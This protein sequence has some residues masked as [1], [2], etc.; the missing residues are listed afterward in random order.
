MDFHDKLRLGTDWDKDGNN[1]STEITN[2]LFAPDHQIS[3]QT[4]I[5]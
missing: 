1:L 4:S 2:Y 3:F 5:Q